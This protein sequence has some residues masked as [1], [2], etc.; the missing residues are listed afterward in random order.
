MRN[1]FFLALSE[2]EPF[3]A[4]HL[5]K[6]SDVRSD[7]HSMEASFGSLSM[8]IR[9]GFIFISTLGCLYL[10]GVAWMPGTTSRNYFLLASF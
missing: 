3:A 9:R 1:A 10:L 4:T 8:D 5:L 2:R 6:D 7:P